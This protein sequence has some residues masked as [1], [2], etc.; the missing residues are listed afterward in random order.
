MNLKT[1]LVLLFKR[2][3]PKKCFKNQL[4]QHA[5]A[6]QSS[7]S[8]PLWNI[9]NNIIFNHL[10]IWVR[11]TIIMFLAAWQL[12]ALKHRLHLL[13]SRLKRFL[14]KKSKTKYRCLHFQKLNNLRPMISIRLLRPHGLSEASK[15]IT[16]S[17]RIHTWHN[18]TKTIL[19]TITNTRFLCK[20]RLSSLFINLESTLRNNDSWHFKKRITWSVIWES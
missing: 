13:M 4:I 18:L 20:L 19:L 8:S 3:L 2:Q 1:F 6:T 12:Q 15:I 11:D 14:L 5:Y 16:L 7:L 17:L 9:L 10:R